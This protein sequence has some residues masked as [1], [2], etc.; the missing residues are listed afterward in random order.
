MILIGDIGNTE[1]KIFL[2]TS[3]KK[4]K[5]KFILKTKK[6]SKYYINSKLNSLKIYSERIEKILFSSVVPSVY[7]KLKSYIKKKLKKNCNELKE[8]NLKK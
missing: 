5:K 8:K 1:V 7:T 6:I 4:I 3:K 2:L